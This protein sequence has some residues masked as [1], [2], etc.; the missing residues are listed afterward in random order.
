MISCER[1][2]GLLGHCTA[3]LSH[4]ENIRIDLKL[5][6]SEKASGCQSSR[7]SLRMLWYLVQG[8]VIHDDLGM[9]EGQER[10]GQ[11]LRLYRVAGSQESPN[12]MHM[13]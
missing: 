12:L 3:F 6:S 9:R 4:L 8:E 2:L 7:M 10:Y 1:L 11:G 5:L 13:E